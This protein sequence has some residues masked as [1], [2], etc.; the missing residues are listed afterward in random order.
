MAQGKDTAIK[1]ACLYRR[2]LAPTFKPIWVEEKIYLDLPEVD[3][4]IV[5]I[6]DLYTEDKCLRDLKTASKKW[7]E[8]K[9]HSSDQPTAYRE[10]IKQ[11]SGE[12][13]QSISFDV[14]V[15]SK[16]PALQCIPTT[17]NDDD[18]AVLARKFQRMLLAIRAG[19][20]LPAEPCAWICSPK[21]CGYWFT[22][23]Y[24]PPHRKT[25]PKRSA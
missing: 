19:I 5:T 4:P 24:V 22:C 2:E 17:R 8:D 25:L 11:R 12:Y 13:P 10:A 16:T 15:S 6:L 18:L 23:P 7:T 3:L 20:F 9:A 21:F 14:L 1:L